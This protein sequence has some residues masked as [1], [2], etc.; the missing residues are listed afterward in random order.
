FVYFLAEWVSAKT[1]IIDLEV[2]FPAQLIAGFEHGPMRAA[3]GD[4]AHGCPSAFEHRSWHKR[5][6]S[7]KLARQAVNV[8]HVI[9]WTFAVLSFF[10]MAA[11][12]SEVGGLGMIGSG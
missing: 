2:R 10:I 6:G 1:Q 8:L 3:V 4:H 7:F 11:A 12:A 5:P 9:I